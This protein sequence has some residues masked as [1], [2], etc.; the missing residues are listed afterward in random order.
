VISLLPGDA[1]PDAD[2]VVFGG[3]EDS[4]AVG[5]EGGGDDVVGVAG[6]GEELQAG[7]GFPEAYG[8]VGL[9]GDDTGTVGAKGGA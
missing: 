4:G 5:A 8:V 7:L 2:C 6:E 3:R 1:V 9:G